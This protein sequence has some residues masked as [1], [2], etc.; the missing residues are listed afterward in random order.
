MT[1]PPV[2]PPAPDT[3]TFIFVPE[4]AA[5]VVTTYVLRPLWFAVVFFINARREAWGRIRAALPIA[6]AIVAQVADMS[7]RV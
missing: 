5:A 1:S 4:S 3:A 2:L 6:V 7:D